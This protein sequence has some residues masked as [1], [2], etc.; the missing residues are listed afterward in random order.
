[1]KKHD[2]PIFIS[3][4]ISLIGTI[5]FLFILPD[6]VPVHFNLSGEADSIGSKFTYLIFPFI[7][8]CLG[9]GFS[10]AAKRAKDKISQN[11]FII[12]GFFETL[13]FAFLGFYFMCSV[14]N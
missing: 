6:Q 4:L 7:G 14:R 3:V 2:L 10:F 1:M 8:F 9:A 11:I 13:L 5:V 12:S